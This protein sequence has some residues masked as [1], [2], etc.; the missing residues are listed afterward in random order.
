M[1]SGLQNRG[2]KKSGEID[3]FGKR[4][5]YGFGQILENFPYFYFS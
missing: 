3:I 1:F 5:V 2:V 4:L